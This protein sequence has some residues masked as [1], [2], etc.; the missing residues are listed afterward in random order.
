MNVFVND[1]RLISFFSERTLKMIRTWLPALS[2]MAVAFSIGAAE[3]A[4]LRGVAA[5]TDIT[6]AAGV[7]LDGPI[8]LHSAAAQTCALS[9]KKPPFTNLYFALN[10]AHWSGPPAEAARNSR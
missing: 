1:C 6:P 7:L 4:G 8:S 10:T 3:C 2:W 9:R 5:K